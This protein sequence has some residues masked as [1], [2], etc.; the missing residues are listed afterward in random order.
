M[1]ATPQEMTRSPHEDVV[2]LARSPHEDV[3]EV[4]RPAGNHGEQVLAL[5]EQTICTSSLVPFYFDLP[6]ESIGHTVI[7]AS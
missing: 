1:P 5:R 3:V 4:P 2:E 7:L 6:L